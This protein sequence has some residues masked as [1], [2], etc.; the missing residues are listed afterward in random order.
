MDRPMRG[1]IPL[2]TRRRFSAEFKAK[3]ALEAIRFGS[4]VPA[5]LHEIESCIFDVPV[6]TDFLDMPL[7]CDG[8]VPLAPADASETSPAVG[9]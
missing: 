7:R 3:A 6:K 4:K 8:H 1:T 5:W 9:Y 2:K